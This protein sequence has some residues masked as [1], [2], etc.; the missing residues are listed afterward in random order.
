MTGEQLR[1]RGLVLAAVGIGFVAWVV[2]LAAMAEVGNPPVLLA[3]AVSG[4]LVCLCPVAGGV[5][6]TRLVDAA[7][8]ARLRHVFV[9]LEG[10]ALV[11]FFPFYWFTFGL[12]PAGRPDDFALGLVSAL[13]APVVA[14]LVLA[15]WS[16]H[17][18]HKIVVDAYGPLVPDSGT[19]APAH[20]IRALGT[21]LVTVGVVLSAGVVAVVFTAPSDRLALEVIGLLVTLTPLLLGVLLVRVTD[22]HSARRRNIASYLVLP[23]ASGFAMAKFASTGGALGMLFAALVFGAVV[24]LVVAFVVVREYT[25]KWDRPWRTSWRA[26]SR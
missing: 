3:V 9:V 11:I 23:A 20:R 8:A 6:A 5:A 2:V 14:A 15:M 17:T 16:S 1:R 7:A 24:T 4:A 21:V 12:E 10:T 18:A 13:A 26:V 19:G 25:G 22:V